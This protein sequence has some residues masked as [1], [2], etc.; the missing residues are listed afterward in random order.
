MEISLEIAPPFGDSSIG[1]ERREKAICIDMI[2][3]VQAN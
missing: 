2:V 3:V 1:K